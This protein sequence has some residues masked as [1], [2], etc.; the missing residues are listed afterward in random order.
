MSQ[1]LLKPNDYA[2]YWRYE[3]GVN[4]IPATN[5]HDNPELVKKPFWTDEHNKQNWIKWGNYQDKPITKEQHD[6]WKRTNAFKDGL[7]IVCGETFHIEENLW[8]NA[9]DCDSKQGIDDFIKDKTLEEIATDTL[10]EQHDNKEKCHILFYTKEPLHNE[11]VGKIEIKSNC[12][13]RDRNLIT[14][15]NIRCFRKCLYIKRAS[16]K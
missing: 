10:V 13:G 8:L 4:V 14:S 9:I 6:E 5:R 16:F 1:E 11:T 15:R 3:I 2:D 12:N 7:A